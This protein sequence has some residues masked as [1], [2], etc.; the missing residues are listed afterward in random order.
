ML[1]RQKILSF[2]RYCFVCGASTA[3]YTIPAHQCKSC[4]SSFVRIMHTSNRTII[5]KASA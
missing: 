3:H 1:Q 2:H 4:G 5:S